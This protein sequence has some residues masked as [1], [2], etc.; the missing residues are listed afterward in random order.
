MPNARPVEIVSILHNIHYTQFMRALWAWLAGIFRG[1]LM[2]GASRMMRGLREH[3]RMRTIITGAF[4][5][6]LS[7]SAQAA[8]PW[9][10][11]QQTLAATSTAALAVDWGQTL[12]ISNHPG[13]FETNPILGRHPTR[14]Q[15]NRYFASSIVGSLAVAHLLPSR[16]RTTWLSAVTMLEVSV[17]A[18]NYQI[19][20]GL[21]F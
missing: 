19:G 20:V 12:D 10:P 15:I 7:L 1:C 13:L 8:D 14:A 9:T 11:T 18:H 2:P 17:S 16:F 5:F 6:G 3:A 21:N 4:L